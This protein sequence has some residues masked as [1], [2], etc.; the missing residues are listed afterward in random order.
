VIAFSYSP[1]GRFEPRWHYFNPLLR[2]SRHCK[3]SSESNHSSMLYLGKLY[4]QRFIF[5]T[6]DAG[7]SRRSFPVD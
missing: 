4:Y 3:L 2:H 1:V 5:V 6:E 7:R